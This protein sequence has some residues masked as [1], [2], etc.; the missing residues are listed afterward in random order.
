MKRIRHKK[1][2]RPQEKKEVYLHN[3]QITVPEVRVIVDE[4]G[5]MLGV[6]P[7]EKALETAREHELDLVLVSPKAQPPVAKIIDYGRYAYQKEK[8]A[9]KQKAQS[10]STELKAIRLS[11]RIGQHD[12][13]FKLKNVQKFLNKGD[14]VK[15]EVV[16]KS[17]ERA[18]PEIGRE[19]LEKTLKDLESTIEY[20]IEQ[21][22]KRQG[23]QFNA[24]IVKPS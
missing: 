3:Q 23:N 15:I 5:E 11:P 8:Q 9:K 17:R 7:T 4:T 12:V 1:K 10:K 13:D 21:P 22:I 18:H 6:L 19:F 16:L 20:K 14:K 24:I 2:F